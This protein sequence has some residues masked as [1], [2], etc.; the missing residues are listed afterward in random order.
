MLPRRDLAL[1][2]GLQED[3]DAMDLLCGMLLQQH[4]LMWRREHPIPAG[5]DNALKAG[6]SCLTGRRL[7]RWL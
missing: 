2:A 5:P 1:P 4:R 3:F 6:Y 7:V